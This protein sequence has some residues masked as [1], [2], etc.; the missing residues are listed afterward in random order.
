M[1]WLVAN[2]KYKEAEAVLKKAAKVNK[3]PYPD[4][5]FTAD[6]EELKAFQVENEKYFEAKRNEENSK[7]FKR[8]VT[9]E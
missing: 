4:H 8:S 5:I 9:S 1:P 7:G 3:I 2:K 6:A